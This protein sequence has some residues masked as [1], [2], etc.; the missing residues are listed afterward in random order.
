MSPDSSNDPA[1][2]VAADSASRTRTGRDGGGAGI[3][4]AA[5]IV[6]LLVGMLGIFDVAASAAP[7]I[8][9]T[10]PDFTALDSHGNSVQ[11]HAYQGKTVVLEWTNA[12]CPYTRKHYTSGNMQSVQGLAQQNGVVWLTVI[13]SAP[14][15]QGFVNGPAANALTQSR[16]AVPTAVL[17]DPS[18]AVARLYAAKTTPHLFVIDKNGALQYMGGMDSIATTDEAD[19]PRAQPYLKEA[20]L[21]VVQGNPVPHPVTKPYGCSIKY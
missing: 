8:G 21:A 13:S 17:L 16:K 4:A 19:I 7:Q 18:G 20:M 5:V 11:L 9:Q 15:K 14:G 10:A 12:D 2:D 3:T 6:A 1:T